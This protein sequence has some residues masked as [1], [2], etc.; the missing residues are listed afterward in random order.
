MRQRDAVTI[1]LSLS[2][3]LYDNID[4]SQ[5]SGRW[6]EN[7]HRVEA[8]AGH[9]FASVLRPAPVGAKD[10]SVAKRE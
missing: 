4:L 6:L 8:L 2:L 7:E 1:S 5:A 10:L 9:H 3:S